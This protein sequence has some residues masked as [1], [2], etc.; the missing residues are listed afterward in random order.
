MTTN[1]EYNEWSIE[2]AGVNKPQ[3]PLTSGYFTSSP[4]VIDLGVRFC[5]QQQIRF[6]ADVG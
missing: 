4:Y 2:V 3:R 5:V 1:E 6:K